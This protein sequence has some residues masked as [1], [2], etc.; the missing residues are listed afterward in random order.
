[1]LLLI[2]L[3]HRHTHKCIAY[4]FVYDLRGQ[5][6]CLLNVQANAETRQCVMPFAHI[7]DE[8]AR[9]H[10]SI[11][12]RIITPHRIP[13]R[14]AF[15]LCMNARLRREWDSKKKKKRKRENEI[16]SN[17]YCTYNKFKNKQT[18]LRKETTQRHAARI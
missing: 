11:V 16:K 1:M 10:D 8:R 14:M 15:Y 4:R 12:C 7:E 17:T 2:P 6:H 9:A 18:I 3:T 5:S 13:I